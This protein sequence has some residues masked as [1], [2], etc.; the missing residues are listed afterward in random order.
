MPVSHVFLAVG[1][2][3]MDRDDYDE[4]FAATR[5]VLRSADIAFA[6]SR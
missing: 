3:A 4:S 1:D 6:Q 5:D 2:F